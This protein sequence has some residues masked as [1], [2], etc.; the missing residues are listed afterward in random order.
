MG[1]ALKPSTGTTDPV[2]AAVRALPLPTDD[3]G[4]R[5]NLHTATAAWLRSRGSDHTRR[6]YFRDLSDY[7]AWCQSTDLD[8]RQAKRGDVDAYTAT[9]CEHLSASSTARRLSCLSSWYAYLVSNEVAPT[10]P[11]DAVDRPAV[12]RD[13]SP[14]V[15]LTGEQVATFMRAA[16]AATHRNAARDAA[17]LAML[18]E[19][20]LRVGEALHLDLDSFRHN[21]GHRTVRV[22]GKG[23]KEREL[24][25]PPPLGRDL[26]A[27]LAVR[28]NDPGPA[29]VTSNGTR[30]DQ[31]ATFRMVRRTARAAGLP[32]PDSLSPHSLRHSVATAALDKGAALRDVQDLLGHADPRTT[33]RYDRSRGSLDRSPAYLIASLFADDGKGDD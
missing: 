7:L 30:V 9:R 14:T 10:N 19:L 28:G 6:G 2:L 16:R 4:N 22:V 31:P 11:V 25:I 5:W 32:N 18:A 26:D 3:A 29:F 8:P 33:R 1:T 21:R 17:L 27:Y 20:G 24:P 12:N 13:A 15:G 23:G